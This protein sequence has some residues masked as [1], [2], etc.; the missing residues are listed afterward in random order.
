VGR[1]HVDGH[2]PAPL[3]AE[4]PVMLDQPREKREVIASDDAAAMKR[5]AHTLAT[6]AAGPSTWPRTRWSA[7]RLSSR[8]RGLCVTR[9]SWGRFSQRGVVRLPKRTAEG[10]AATRAKNSR[11]SANRNAGS[12]E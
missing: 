12:V 4:V 3:D 8:V 2:Q 11:S 10:C 9:P 6:A 5:T 1:G 7:I